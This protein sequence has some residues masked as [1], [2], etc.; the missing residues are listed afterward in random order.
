M[1][2]WAL[3]LLIIG[4]ILGIII[5]AV[6]GIYFAYKYFK[7]QLRENPPI[8]EEQIRSLYAQMGRKPSEQQIKS[9]MATYKRQS[10]QS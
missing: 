3:A 9:I 2:T 10:Q 8:T 6:L 1:Q 4:P 5:G 7:K